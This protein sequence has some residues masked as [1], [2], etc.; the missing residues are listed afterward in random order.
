[1]VEVHPKMTGGSTRLLWLFR[2]QEKMR[3]L[4]KQ[5]ETCGTDK[6]IPD[7]LHSGMMGLILYDFNSRM[8]N[9]QATGWRA[10][11]GRL[12]QEYKSGGGDETSNF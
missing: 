2:W 9:R 12:I 11:V 10:G 4:E 6:P 5:Y 1:M 3:V 8:T 7:G